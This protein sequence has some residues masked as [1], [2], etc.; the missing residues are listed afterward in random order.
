[1]KKIILLA[2][3]LMAPVIVYPLSAWV[4]GRHIEGV[5]DGQYKQLANN[6][7][8][9]LRQYQVR[10]G[11]FETVE[12][13]E[14]EWTSPQAHRSLPGCSS[15]AGTRGDAGDARGGACEGASAP[16]RF[17]TRTVVRHGPYLGKEG[18]GLAAAH[19]EFLFGGVER[20]P[21]VAMLY[22][23]AAPLTVDAVFRFGGDGHWVMRSPAVDVAAPDRSRIRWG[24]IRLE[25]AFGS[26]GQ[27]TTLHG[28]LPFVS[29]VSAAGVPVIDA[30]AIHLD[31]SLSRLFEDNPYLYGGPLK[32]TL[33]RLDLPAHGEGGQALALEQLVVESRVIQAGAFLD[34]EAGLG[35]RTLNVAERQYGPARIDIALRHMEGRAFSRL[36]HDYVRMAQ[37]HG[38]MLAG[39]GSHDPARLMPLMTSARSVLEGSPEFHLER[40]DVRLPQGQLQARGVVSLPNARADGLDD[41]DAFPLVL[42]D[43][44]ASLEVEGKMVVPD[45]LAV[46]WVGDE[47]RALI[48][49]LVEEGYLDR[50]GPS[51]SAAIRHAQGETMVNGKRF[52][53]ALQGRPEAPVERGAATLNMPMPK[54]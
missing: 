46:E 43:L 28:G 34:V 26:E 52:D 10:R 49:R 27:G 37:D 22:G 42:R 13:A 29:V 19:T 23:E 1:M 30:G 33:D 8:V 2:G 45:R 15:G 54:G 35:V 47:Q 11:V 4:L 51:F 14:F 6:A 41:A 32:V 18:F 25:G 20:Y 31:A 40:L 24:D 50:T 39:A 3:L 48:A 17:A 5:F 36:Q 16:I 21:L 12:T 44:I 7:P 53:P 9:K 38:P